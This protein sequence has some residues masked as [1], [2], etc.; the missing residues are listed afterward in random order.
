MVKLLQMKTKAGSKTTLA[1][2]GSAA[3]RDAGG[4]A[5]GPSSNSLGLS[6]FIAHSVHVSEDLPED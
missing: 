2:E 1:D 4:Q 5:G 6:V 3:C